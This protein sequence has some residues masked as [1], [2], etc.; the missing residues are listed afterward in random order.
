MSI[1]EVRN[2]NKTYPAFTLSDVSFDIEEGMITGFVGR[3]GAGKSTTIKSM[4]NLVH[5][6]S[7]AISYFGKAFPQECDMLYRKS[8]LIFFS[9]H[10]FSKSQEKDKG[11]RGSGEKF[12]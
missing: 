10:C 12:L 1:V 6:D 8:S 2:L 11:Y 4:L 3:N 5:P 9:F 7:G